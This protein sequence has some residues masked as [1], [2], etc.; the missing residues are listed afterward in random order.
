[1]ELQRMDEQTPA[2]TDMLQKGHIE[3]LV[4]LANT[5]S[6][7]TIIPEIFRGNPANCLLAAETAWRLGLPTVQLMRAMYVA[8][9]GAVFGFTAEFFVAQLMRSGRIV[10]A[11]SYETE[12]LSGELLG[13]PLQ[14]LPDIQVTA[15]VV[16]QATGAMV[17]KSV[18]MRQAV[19]MGW[20]RRMRRNDGS[21]EMPSKYET[22][23]EEM[24]QKRAI[25]WL[26]RTHYAD[27]MYGLQEAD[28]IEDVR[29]DELVSQDTAERSAI[30]RLSG[31]PQIQERD[32]RTIEH[33]EPARAVDEP[34]E[35][36][37]PGV[38]F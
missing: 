16:D 34:E 32:I 1:M 21:G 15:R 29:R 25:T 11:P 8:K 4:A 19:A 20:T 31:R 27:V 30:D 36:A 2:T 12:L 23:G 9:R 7:S 18:S 14:G 6:K 17:Q 26:V 24:L 5:L 10:G 28:E 13:D 38:L 35:D 3:A 37:E 22:M 33:E